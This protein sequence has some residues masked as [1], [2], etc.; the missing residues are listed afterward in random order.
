M[1]QCVV[2]PL[3]AVLV[4]FLLSQCT[5]GAVYPFNTKRSRNT[6]EHLIEAE[7][8]NTFSTND[9]YVND[10]GDN[11]YGEPVSSKLRARRQ[12]TGGSPRAY[13]YNLL[14]SRNNAQTIYSGEGSKVN[15]ASSQ[16]VIIHCFASVCHMHVAT[17]CAFSTIQL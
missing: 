4:I 10:A 15:I 14:D 11:G 12:T 17:S 5:Q 1:K 8:R 16:N 2:L 9:V 7:Y 3:A 6:G 13:S